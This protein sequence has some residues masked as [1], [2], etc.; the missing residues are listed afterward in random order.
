MTF[1][2]RWHLFVSQVWKSVLK[3]IVKSLF[4]DQPATPY[5]L[6]FAPGNYI[7]SKIPQDTY[8]KLVAK[9]DRI[10]KQIEVCIIKTT[11][12]NFLKYI[13]NVLNNKSAY[14]F[15]CKHIKLN[16]RN[17]SEKFTTI[18]FPL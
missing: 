7:M 16:C 14:F 6:M 4:S 2:K 5:A 3:T 10:R 1:F 11:Y 12:T 18:Y 15:M 8:L 13:V 17:N 9:I